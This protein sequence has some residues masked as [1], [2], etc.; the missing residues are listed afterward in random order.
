MI[1]ISSTTD[2]AP[3][4]IQDFNFE[5]GFDSPVYPLLFKKKCCKKWKKKGEHKRC[6]K[7][8]KRLDFLGSEVN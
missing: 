8:P 3:I 1:Q 2:F 5:N 4:L 6:K 7:C